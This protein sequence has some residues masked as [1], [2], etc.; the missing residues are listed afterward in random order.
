MT[1]PIKLTLADEA[2]IDVGLVIATE[3]AVTAGTVGFMARALVHQQ[4]GCAGSPVAHRSLAS[5]LRPVA[6]L[7]TFSP[8]SRQANLPNVKT[9]CWVSPCGEGEA[10]ASE[11]RRGVHLDP[12]CGVCYGCS[13]PF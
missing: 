11:A 8:E 2:L 5:H 3:D 12:A 1:D 10:L 4:A 13:R 6:H 7:R 9:G